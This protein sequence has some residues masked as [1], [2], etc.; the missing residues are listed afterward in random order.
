MTWDLDSQLWAQPSLWARLCFPADVPDHRYPKFLNH[1]LR[2]ALGAGVCVSLRRPRLGLKQLENNTLCASGQQCAGPRLL[3]P[4]LAGPKVSF[5]SIKVLLFS[6]IKNK[7]PAPIHLPWLFRW[8]CEGLD[9]G[10]DKRIQM[11]EACHT[12]LSLP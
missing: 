3:R 2:N 5:R 6:G 7:A 9:R 8:Y 10:G 12:T 4:A 11:G 1:P